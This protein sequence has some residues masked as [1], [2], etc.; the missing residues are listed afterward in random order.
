MH[1][2]ALQAFFKRKFFVFDHCW[3]HGACS[4]EF[5]ALFETLNGRIGETLPHSMFELRSSQGFGYLVTTSR[6]VQLAQQ[7][8]VCYTEGEIMQR[9]ARK[10]GFLL[11]Y[12]AQTTHRPDSVCPFSTQSAFAILIRISPNSHLD[13]SEP[14]QSAISL[15]AIFQPRPKDSKSWGSRSNGMQRW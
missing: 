11:K 4:A 6:A 15:A 2:R 9:P 13:F 12:R 14:R 8:S 5:Y 10:S 7:K 1:L 3:C